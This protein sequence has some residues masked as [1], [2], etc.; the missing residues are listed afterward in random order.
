[1]K[2]CLYNTNYNPID[3][4][5]YSPARPRSIT[6]HDKWMS[7]QGA[8]CLER[9]L[10]LKLTSESSGTRTDDRS[11]KM[12]SKKW[13]FHRTTPESTWLLVLFPIFTRARSVLKWSTVVTLGYKLPSPRFSASIE[14]KVLPSTCGWQT[15][16]SMETAQMNYIPWLH[17]S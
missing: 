7:L 9:L 8:T 6:N 15:G 17:Q 13:S 14:S 10:V 12:Q 16:C 2:Y 11:L 1:M 4:F 5:N 3:M